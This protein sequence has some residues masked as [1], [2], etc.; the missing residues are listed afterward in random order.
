MQ[1]KIQDFNCSVYN[2]EDQNEKQKLINQLNKDLNYRR[3][4]VATNVLNLKYALKEVLAQNKI[5]KLVE[6]TRL[7]KIADYLGTRLEDIQ[8]EA[9]WERINAQAQVLE[10]EVERTGKIPITMITSIN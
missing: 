5:Q 9:Y 4:M 10:K 1:L 8:D 3:A 2:L 7:R 6:D